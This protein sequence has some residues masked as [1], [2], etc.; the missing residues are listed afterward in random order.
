MRKILAM[1]TAIFACSAWGQTSWSN[2]QF[3]VSTDDS[4]LVSIVDGTVVVEDLPAA[5]SNPG[6]ASNF[7]PDLIDLDFAPQPGYSL[8]GELVNF[9]VDMH[10]DAYG[11]PSNML[12]DAVAEYKV[13]VNGEYAQ[14][15]TDL[16]GSAHY[17]GVHFLHSPNLISEIDETVME[18]IACPLGDEDNGCNFGLDAVFLEASVRL[19]SF[20]ITPILTPVSEPDTEALWMGGLVFLAA[21]AVTRRRAHPRELRLLLA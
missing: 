2:D 20:T 4:T 1:A 10:A 11:A 12:L 13:D 19:S 16:G 14:S 7:P 17:A 18:G 21:A 5:V 8:A 9:S 6:S 3:S 15:A